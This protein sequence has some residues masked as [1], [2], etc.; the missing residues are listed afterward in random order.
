LG[1]R[2]EERLQALARLIH[3]R[4]WP[5]ILV[6]AA[7]SLSLSLGLPLL[8]LDASNES[9]LRQT[10]PAIRD[11]NAFRDQFGRGKLI[12]AALAA[13]DVFEPAVLRRLKS[14]HQDLA[15]RVPHLREVT[16]LI[17]VRH[18][19]GQGQTL[20]VE[21]FLA[22]LP[23]TGEEAARVREEALS[24]P[25]YLN[26]LVSADAR[27][28]AVVL[29]TEPFSSAARKGTMGTQEEAL[30]GF[31]APSP[32]LPAR[33][34]YLTPAEKAEQAAAV[35]AVA[36]LHQTPGARLLLTGHPL[37]SVL[38]KRIMAGDILR[39]LSLSLA[40]VALLLGLTFRRWSGVVLP[41]LV[42]S[43]ALTSTLGSMGLLGVTIKL[44]TVILPSF[45]L[46]VG[47]GDSV[48]ILALYYRRLDR[49]GSREE[50]VVFALG[51][52]GLA[53]IMTTLTTAAGLLS[54]L[55]AEV[56]PIAELGLF[57]AVGV[58]LALVYTLL[59][60][61]ALLALTPVRERTPPSLA[62]AR[63]PRDRDQG[64][65]SEVLPGTGLLDRFL[66][67]LAGLAA[68]RPRAVTLAGLV[69]LGLALWGTTDLRLS[70][71]PLAWLPPGSDLRRAT[72][73]VDLHLKGS[74]PLEVVVDTGRENG[75]HRPEVLAALDRLAGWLEEGEVKPRPGKVISLARVVKEINQ[76]LHEDR[77]EFYRLPESQRLISQELLLF[78][79]AGSDDL[80]ELVDPAFSRT[81]VTIMLPWHDT[82]DYLPLIR[83]V[84]A[85]FK[86]AL[87]GLARVTVTGHAALYSRTLK[88]LLGSA[89]R[90]YLLCLVAISLMMAL[91]LGNLRL[92][93]A[94]MIPNL[95]PILL[96][97]G[98]MGWADLPFD[99]ETMLI[100]SIALG[101][102]VDDTIHFLV[103]FRRYQGLTGEPK[104]AVRSTLLTSGRA[105]VMTSLVLGAGFLI[106]G[107]A[108]LRPLALFGLLT[109]LAVLLALAADLLQAPAL[110][111]LLYTKKPR[112]S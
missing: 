22:R 57:A 106:F 72:R 11:Y 93:L 34:L 24:N 16:S 30:A 101:L 20:I 64:G 83:Q 79:A 46:V 98:L 88:A 85:S 63:H 102:A 27:L 90:S 95:T 75:L 1:G 23:G 103:N 25:L 89:V 47:V 21:E 109:C 112:G 105:M 26:R 77:P 6:T 100:F 59:L 3:G 54:F 14:L 91:L 87:A 110:M 81:R 94:A 35:L 78:E 8:R 108:S 82:L 19:R 68:A 37:V 104:A 84:E 48:H 40:A 17:N 52:S 111:I 97:L 76:A 107:L 31:R 58:G 4:P 67:T 36:A 33:E 70:H 41:L 10:D 7:L 39:F 53:V 61:P 49:T 12:F 69:L 15:A 9:L 45:L 74:V 62:A 99:L 18:T 38:L 50:A 55:G 65:G 44:P 80:E 96:T 73:V 51:H 32:Q 92:G 13:E 28:A 86:E 71:D 60:L 5:V 29:E 43:L 2:L 42:V 66:G 56:A